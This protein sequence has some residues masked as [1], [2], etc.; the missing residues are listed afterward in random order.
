VSAV[1]YSPLRPF[2]LRMN[3]TSGDL[4]TLV[5]PPKPAPGGASA[6]DADGAIGDADA[7]DAVVGGPAGPSSGK[8]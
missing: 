6:A 2:V 4:A 8:P 1:R 7:S 5:P 3:D